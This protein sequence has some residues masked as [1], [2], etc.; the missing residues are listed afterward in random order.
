[1]LH[2]EEQAEESL[3]KKQEKCISEVLLISNLAKV[4]TGRHLI[5]RENEK[6]Q[7]TNG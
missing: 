2:A 7:E 1:M 6:D 3:S 5:F 4:I